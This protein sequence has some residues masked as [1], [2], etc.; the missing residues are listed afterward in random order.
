[1]SVHLSGVLGVPSLAI[2]G[3]QNTNVTKPKFN[4]SA[5]TPPI[6]TIDPNNYSN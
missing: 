6:N 1:M 3:K 5:Y 4:N 2:F